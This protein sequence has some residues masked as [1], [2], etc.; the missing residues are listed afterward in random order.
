MERVYEK[1]NK[2]EV[3]QKRLG[4]VIAVCFKNQARN[5]DW[6]RGLEKA[7]EN[8]QSMT[9]Y[10]IEETKHFDRQIS[11]IKKECEQLQ[12]TIEKKQNSQM[13]TIERVAEQFILKTSLKEN[14]I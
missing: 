2:A 11:K 6:I 8:M 7:I 3:E 14:L 4:Q 5:D 9:K 1:L 12:K 13:Q 10:T